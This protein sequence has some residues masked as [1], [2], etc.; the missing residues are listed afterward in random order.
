MASNFTMHGVKNVSLGPIKERGAKQNMP[1][2]YTRTITVVDH[3]G[4]TFEL[5]L[6]ATRSDE[7]GIQE[8]YL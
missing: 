4:H 6:F 5:D 7:L 1:P 2:F 3:D 8:S